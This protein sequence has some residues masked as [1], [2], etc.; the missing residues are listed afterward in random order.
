MVEPVITYYVL[1][2]KKKKHI[3]NL[4]AAFQ[5]NKYMYMVLR[6]DFM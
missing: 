6:S 1:F 4:T 3:L 2:K 5:I